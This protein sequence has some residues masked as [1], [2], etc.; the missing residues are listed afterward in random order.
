MTNNHNKIHSV[1]QMMKNLKWEPLANRR[2]K[3]RLTTFYKLVNKEI[4]IP[5]ASLQHTQRQ[6]RNTNENTFLNISVRTDAYKHSFFP[7]TLRDW[8]CLPMDIT[9]SPSLEAFKERT[10]AYFR[11]EY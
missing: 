9:D 7:R 4:A 6:T 8:N 11:C 2:K 5:N 10:S 3:A 1:T